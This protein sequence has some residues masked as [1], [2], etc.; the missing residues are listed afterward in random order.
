ML[1]MRFFLA[2]TLSLRFLRQMTS[3]WSLFL[4]LLPRK[5][6][7]VVNAAVIAP[8]IMPMRIFIIKRV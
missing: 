1:S 6:S 3:I 4:R 7:R 5:I 2:L 8:E